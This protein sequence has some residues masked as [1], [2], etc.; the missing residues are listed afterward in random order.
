MKEIVFERWSRRELSCEC[1]GDFRFARLA[2]LSQSRGDRRLQAL[3]LLHAIA[4]GR[5]EKLLSLIW[6]MDLAQEFRRVIDVIGSRDVGKLALR[7]TPMRA[8]PRHYADVMVEFYNAHG[9]SRRK[10]ESKQALWD[11]THALQLRLGVTNAEIYHA[12]DLNPGNANA[13]LKH[14]MLEKLSLTNA[15][16]ILDYLNGM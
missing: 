2:A 5:T 14:A 3:L 4:S 12:L 10:A 6:D 13:Y 1:G 15:Q 7:G 11:E 8:L 9:A 16:R